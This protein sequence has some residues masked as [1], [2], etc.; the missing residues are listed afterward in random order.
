[1]HIREYRGKVLVWQFSLSYSSAHVTASRFL[2]FCHFIWC[3]NT[4]YLYSIFIAMKNNIDLIPLAPGPV[5]IGHIYAKTPAGFPSPAEDLAVNR[6]DIGAILVKNPTA[7]YY[8]CVKG[9]SMTDAG[10]DD[11]DHLIVDRSVTPKHN[12]IVIA[13]IN[14]DVTVKRLFKRNG[15]IKLR[16]ENVTF[17]D[18]VPSAEQEWSIWGVVTYIIK[19]TL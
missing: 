12:H 4:V 10:I 1:M 9:N 16:A 7:T 18:I 3:I 6:I 8:M 14:G 15:I 19:S 2:T 5:K 17:P 11:G 13:E